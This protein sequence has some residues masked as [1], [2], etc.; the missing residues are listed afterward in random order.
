VGREL[1]VN[2]F[3]DGAAELDLRW[4]VDVNGLKF[5]RRSMLFLFIW[6]GCTD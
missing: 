5:V 4:V 3:G 6:D 1:G 2:I